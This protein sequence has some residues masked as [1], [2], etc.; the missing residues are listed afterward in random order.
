MCSSRNVG[1]AL[2]G[3]LVVAAITVAA[4]SGRKP[5]KEQQVGVTLRHLSTS[6]T[7]DILRGF[8]ELVPSYLSSS[9][10]DANELARIFGFV[11][12]TQ[13]SLARVFPAAHFYVGH[14][15]ASPPQHPYLMAIDEGK[16]YS[17][18]YG[19]NRLL[20]DNDLKVTDKN[21]VE[22]AE[23]FVIAAVIDRQGPN[24]EVTFLGTSKTKHVISGGDYDASLEV[25]IGQ[26]IEEWSFSLSKRGQLGTVYRRGPKGYIDSYDP[27]EAKPLPTQGRLETQPSLTVKT[28]PTGNAHVEYEVRPSD[29]LSHYYVT[30]ELNGGE[31]GLDT[32][33]F[34]LDRFPSE[35]TNVY[36][37]V[38]DEI[39]GV[40]RYLHPGDFGG[41][42][43]HNT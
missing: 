43:G 40:D 37:R 18:P 2:V 7:M 29:T 33:V 26:Q 3:L 23:A 4:G 42:R 14:D 25:R 16:G 1:V 36:V 35:S 5:A 6:E 32:V 34:A 8:P 30:A 21:I 20:I 28:S 13:A 31:Y 41:F 24:V 9:G 11:E 17:M 19:F 12:V 15:F 27:A 10:N 38:R 39:R 22:L